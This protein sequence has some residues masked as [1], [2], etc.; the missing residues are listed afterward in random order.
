MDDAAKIAENL[1]RD[2][3]KGFVLIKY[4]DQEIKVYEASK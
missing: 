3:I 2:G 4:G 1:F